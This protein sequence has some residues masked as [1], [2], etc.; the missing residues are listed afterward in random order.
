MRKVLLDQ[1]V[2]LDHVVKT[3]RERKRE[4]D[5]MQLMRDVIHLR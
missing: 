2:W 1:M 3:R 5:E 4:I